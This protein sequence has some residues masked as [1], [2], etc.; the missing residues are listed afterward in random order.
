MDGISLGSERIVSAGGG[1]TDVA[2]TLATEIATMTDLLSQ[3]RGG[4]RS[5]TAAPRFA[6]LM[7]V[8]LDQAAQLKDALLTHGSSLVATGQG[9]A[10]AESELSTALPGVPS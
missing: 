7:Q 6:S 5:D 2:D 10:S 3:V 4:W 1:V 9:F 8:Y